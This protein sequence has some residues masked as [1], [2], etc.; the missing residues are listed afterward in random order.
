MNKDSSNDNA[1]VK[2]TERQLLEL[3]RSLRPSE[4]LRPRTMEAAK[5]VSSS[6][7]TQRRVSLFCVLA[8]TVAVAGKPVARECGWLEPA[9]SFTPSA[10][11]QSVSLEIAEHDRSDP[12][13]GMLDAFCR[14]RDLQIQRL[15]PPTALQSQ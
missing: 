3:G 5:D 11:L 12:H 9:E 10:R 13:W 2:E 7:V 8:I 14:W 15:R 6:Q 1:A 4:D